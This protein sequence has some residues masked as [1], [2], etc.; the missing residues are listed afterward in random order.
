MY[1][2]YEKASV[3]DAW[4]DKYSTKLATLEEFIGFSDKNVVWIK[5][6]Y[7]LILHKTPCM[8][9]VK[10]QLKSSSFTV[11]SV[12]ILNILNSDNLCPIFLFPACTV[13]TLL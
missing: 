1:L 12:W 5:H 3:K 8:K 9:F 7:S 11:A 4:I 10:G 13:T 2:Q 6:D